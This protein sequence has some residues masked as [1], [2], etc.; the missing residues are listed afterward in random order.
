MHENKAPVILF[1]MSWRATPR[2]AYFCFIICSRP[3]HQ[4]KGRCRAAHLCLFNPRQGDVLCVELRVTQRFLSI[5]HRAA[6]AS[7]LLFNSPADHIIPSPPP[8]AICETE[9]CRETALKRLRQQFCLKLHS[10]WKKCICLLDKTMAFW[11]RSHR[12]FH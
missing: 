12:A 3:E 5:I 7:V 8:K 10:W 9:P 4:T 1:L 2:T 6:A 11:G